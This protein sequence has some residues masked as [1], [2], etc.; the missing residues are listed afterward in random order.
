MIVRAF[1]PCLKPSIH[2]IKENTM[3]Y[4]QALIPT[5]KENPVDAELPSHRLMMRAGYIEQLTAGIY[6]L[7]PLAW[8]S[9]QKI[10]AIIREE[11]NAAGAQELL[12][13]MV[14]PAEIWQLSGRWDHYGK[15]LLRFKD[16]KEQDYCLSPTHEEGITDL[17]KRHIR[18]YR[19][20]PIN[21]FQIQV[22]FR[23]EVRPRGG[24]MRGR[25]FI[26][27]DGYSFDVD[28]ENAEIAYK[29][30][31]DAYSRIF[32]RCGL[33]FR[34]V[35]ADS[36]NIGGSHSHEFQVLAQTGE[37]RILSCPKCGYAANEEKAEV[38]R[39]ES[40]KAFSPDP[41][42]PAKEEVA[43]G[44]A[45]SIDEV[46]A[47]FND[48]PEH[49]IKTLVYLADAKPVVIL[50]RGNDNLNEIKLTRLLN[51]ENL[52][53]A[54][55][56]AIEE[57][58]GSKAGALGPCGID[59]PIY[60]DLN[61]AKMHDCICGANHTDHHFV[62][63]EPGRDFKVNAIA[64][65]ILAQE[66][67][68][69]PHC[70]EKLQAFKGI[71]VG[72]VFLLGTKYSVP[73]GA[74]YLDEKGDSHPCVMGCYGIGV[75]R[76]LAAAIEQY[77]DENGINLPAAIAPYHVILAPL[78]LRSEAI[79]SVT[80]KLYAELQNAGIEVLYDDR[81]IRPGVKFKDDD[82]IG[83]PYRITI[84]EKN[85]ANNKVEFKHRTEKDAQLVDLDKIVDVVKAQ[86]AADLDKCNA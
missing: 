18:S 65:L 47:F 36:G 40:V 19:S 35:E 48:V 84:G 83:V 24:L 10:E 27:K 79:L 45:H 33:E 39:D 53:M 51:C 29:K 42:T 9:V 32:K 67:D 11:L 49:S 72:H 50:M 30:M 5:R 17:A 23:D 16:R 38:K 43:T 34:A 58:M 75:T 12:L 78:Q 57:V 46:A 86:I 60:A 2:L 80:E 59:L 77:N 68:A 14:Q 62:H 55:D 20:M 28:Y 44:D 8:R 73:M 66:G 15:E 21:L 31:Y 41:Q 7:M 25:E 82:L 56:S 71:E 4:S 3:R 74:T 1:R 52:V 70:G 63:V 37:D 69:C 6:T 85:L 76:V 64:D 81:D 26:M 61:V 54:S 13:P 22:K